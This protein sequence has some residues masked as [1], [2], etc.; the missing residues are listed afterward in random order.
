MVAHL[1]C[2]FDGRPGYHRMSSR[3]LVDRGLGAWSPKADGR[4]FRATPPTDQTMRNYAHWLANF[5]EW[6]EIRGVDLSTC[7]YVNHIYGRY[8]SEMLSG[9]W[10]CRGMA[11]RPGTVNPRVQQACDYLTWMAEKG[12]RRPFEV[13]HTTVKVEAF[14]ATSSIGHRLK[15]V[16]TREGKVRQ[17]K[18]RLRM[19]TDSQVKSWLANVYR[20]FG[21][22]EGLMCE[23]VLLTAMR[24]EEVA[25]LRTDTLPEEPDHWHLSNADAPRH[26]QQ[27]LIT[28]KFG[29]KGASYGYDHGDKIGPERSIWIPLDLAVRLH[30]YRRKLRNPALKLWIQAAPTATVKRH[31]IKESVHLFLKDRTGT[32]I[33]GKDLYNTWTGVEL[34]YKGW[35]PHLGRHWWAC[36]ILWREL[37][38]HEKLLS[39][40]ADTVA[41]LLESTGLSIIRLLIQP[42]LGHA[43]DSTSMIYLQWAMDMIGVGLSI[44]YEAELDVQQAN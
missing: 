11:L 10:S 33:T 12:H 18:R 30:E 16:Q 2:I 22:T 4:V 27:V 32:R 13:P 38:K 14:S 21:N 37:N 9:S 43:H 6:V 1:P 5:L 7:D 17:D 3:Y 41:A 15:E 34:P 29:T 19:P 35:S 25:C 26:E 44:Q 42:Q 40:G 39:F 24:R 23:T 8:Q 28:I 36:S 20:K 31:R